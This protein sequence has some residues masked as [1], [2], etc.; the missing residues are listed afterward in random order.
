MAAQ[1]PEGSRDLIGRWWGSAEHEGARTDFGVLISAGDGDS[2]HVYLSIPAIAVVDLDVGAAVRTE[3]GFRVGTWEVKHDRALDRMSGLLPEALVP[4]YSIPFELARVDSLP[5]PVVREAGPLREPAWLLDTGAPIWAGVAGDSE[6]VYVGNEH[7]EVASVGHEDGVAR[8]VTRIGAPIRSTPVVAGEAL[9]VL[10]DDGA[11][12]R[13]NRRSGSVEWSTAVSSPVQRIDPGLDGSRYDPY[14]A[15]VALVDGAAIIGT[16]DGELVAVDERSGAIR[17][18]TDLGAPILGT[19]TSDGRQVFFTTFAGE[20]GAVLAPN[21]EIA[22]RVQTSGPIVS[23]PSYTDGLLLFGNRSYDLL[24][25]DARNGREV[26]K[27]YNWFSWIESTATVSGP[28]AYVGSSDSQ[29]LFAISVS[30]GSVLWRSYTGGWT[31]ATPAVRDGTVYVGSLGQEGY[32]APHRPGFFGID[33]VTGQK[34]WSFYVDR[35]PAA[36]LFGFA[37]SPYVHGTHV[38]VGGLD[39]RVYAF[40]TG[41]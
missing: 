15:S 18:Q 12:Y 20:V 30:D 26:W 13:I 14:A 38:Y 25:L 21:G 23:S 1:A 32:I 39:G 24:G 28:V 9:F 19:P 36:P 4:V 27:T 2:V 41:G 29:H 31:W 40:R 35:D 17:W 11:L 33:A 22:W 6:A 16:Y 34:Q 7:G 8:W 3:A 5:T 37:S 10:A